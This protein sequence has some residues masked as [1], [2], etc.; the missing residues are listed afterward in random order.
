MT[1]SFTLT[2]TLFPDL[3]KRSTSTSEGTT[4]LNLCTLKHL[5]SMQKIG[6]KDKEDPQNVPHAKRA[7]TVIRTVSGFR[8]I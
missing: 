7:L 5:M 8:Y 1:M 2:L 3:V 4:F 6:E